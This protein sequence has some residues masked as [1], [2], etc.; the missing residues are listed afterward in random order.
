MLG[1]WYGKLHTTYYDSELKTK[2]THE[3]NQTIQ[4]RIYDVDLMVNEEYNEH[5]GNKT[6]H[7]L[8]AIQWALYKLRIKY[9]C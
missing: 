5:D 1:K 9:Q 8:N 6:L 4:D 2:A 3:E 7:E